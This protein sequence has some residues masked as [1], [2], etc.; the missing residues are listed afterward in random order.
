MT[1]LTKCNSG[2][3]TKTKVLYKTKKGLSEETIKEISKRKNEPKWMLEFRLKAYKIFTEKQIPKW[4]EDL[5]KIGLKNLYYYIQPQEGTKENW[6]DVRK[7]IKYTFDKLGVLQAEK[8]FLGGSGAQFESEVVYHS[9]QKNLA[10]KGIIFESTDTALKKYPKL[11]KEYFGKIVPPTDNKFA[12]LNSAVWSGGSFIYIPKGVH[13]ELPLQAYFRMNHE[14]IGQ[15]ERTLIIADEGSSVHYIEGCT[16]TRCL[17]NSRHSAVVEIVAKK[18][19][20]IQYT[21]IQNWSNN[22]YNL[23][24]KRAYAYE[25]AEMHWLDCNI[26]SKLTMKYPSIYL[27]EEGAKGE[28]YSLALAGKGQH[29]DAGAKILHFAKNTKS[30]V[31]SKSISKSDGKTT[32]RGLILMNKGAKDAKTHTSC[33]ALVIDE[34]SRSNTYPQII[35]KEDTSTVQHEATISKIEEEQ[36]FYLMSRGLTE[37]QSIS[38]IVNGFAEPIIK[39]LPTEYAIEINRLLETEWKKQ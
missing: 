2:F 31:I 11:F 34:Q 13:V 12:A 39:R 19:A 3:S 4:S 7:E 10:K 30:K 1:I 17:N 20:H 33:D 25:N 35:S 6:K 5:S 36:L 38:T 29:Q 26:G 32:Y 16:A 28:I 9:L 24:T 23:V 18:N 22:I 15:F 14:S 8:E 27:L 21:T 37:D